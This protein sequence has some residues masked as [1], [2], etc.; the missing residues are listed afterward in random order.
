MERAILER[1]R[2]LYERVRQSNPERWTRATRNW[3]PVGVVTLNPERLRQFLLHDNA[4]T[5][6]TL[7]AK[8]IC[9][10][11]TDLD[12]PLCHPCL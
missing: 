2:D 9:H 12:G 6:L 8:L 10:P 4:P 5:A 7:T 1:R 11:V 3:S